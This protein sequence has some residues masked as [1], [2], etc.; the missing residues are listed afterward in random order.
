MDTNVEKLVD[1]FIQERMQRKRNT[2]TL[3]PSMK[4]Q[5]AHCQRKIA[6]Q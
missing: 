6:K 3:N 2:C 1:M 5:S 4:R